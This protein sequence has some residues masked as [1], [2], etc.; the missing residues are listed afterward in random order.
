MRISK[1]CVIKIL[2]SLSI[3]SIVLFSCVEE[4]FSENTEDINT[5]Y[6]D[7]QVGAQTA[8]SKPPKTSLNQIKLKKTQIVDE[9]LIEEVQAII[10]EDGAYAYTL[11]AKNI[12]SIGE[13]T[14]FTLKLRSSSKKIDLHIIANFSDALSNL[15]LNVGD[16]ETA[17]KARLIQ[18]F[19]I[20]NNPDLLGMWASYSMPQGL[21][22]NAVNDIQGIK[23]LRFAA[24]VDI[25]L[26]NIFNFQFESVQVFRMSNSSQI[27]PNNASEVPAVSEPSVPIGA[28]KI[29]GFSLELF[30]EKTI[31][32]YIPES[33]APAEAEQTTDAVCIIIGGRYQ[34]SFATTFYRIDFNPGIQGHPFGQVLRNHKYIF[35]VS[36][37]SESGKASPEEAANSPS[38]AIEAQQIVW[39]D[40]ILMMNFDNENYFGT[41]SRVVLLAAEAGST[42][43]IL[44]D[45][46]VANYT[47]QWANNYGEPTGPPATNINDGTFKAEISPDQTSIDISALSLNPAGENYRRVYVLAVANKLHIL[48]SISQ[49]AESNQTS[50]TWAISNV[51]MP[52]NFAE[53]PDNL[54]RFYQWNKNEGWPTSGFVQ[55]W[56]SQESS[57]IRWEVAKD[58]C[59][60]GWRVPTSNE[61]RELANSPGTRWREDG[62]YTY[63]G[64]WFADSQDEADAAT[65]GQPGN[66]IFLP[67]GGHRN[68]LGVL[69]N[70]TSNGSYWASDLDITANPYHL[71]FANGSAL[72]YP[73]SY[74]A[75]G[76]L[77]R[78]IKE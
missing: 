3:I 40:Y 8:K 34:G 47:I 31:S 13:N 7:V 57:G 25:N 53:S 16:S 18:V 9:N 58:P 55:N 74:R 70:Q 23:F 60:S 2:S 76:F 32:L 28:S 63:P 65:L 43:D 12:Q 68:E 11:V 59:P 21:S 26:E 50:G 15:E 64:T 6:V 69:S 35:N 72:V 42:Q 4:N 48:I 19:S 5:E 22:A 52:L 38:S 14:S 56:D 77:I 33:V 41:S 75:H 66:A 49:E 24:R 44:V 39:E 17:I 78:C 1:S 20:G 54:G 71:A 51:E 45:T 10:F 29:N 73:Y 62:E 67:A 36:K 37:I 27:I 30:S 61:L 46:D